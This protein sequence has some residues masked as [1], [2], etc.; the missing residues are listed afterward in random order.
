MA[1]L[2][3]GDLAKGVAP[4]YVNRHEV[5]ATG[6]GMVRQVSASVVGGEASFRTV[7]M[8]REENAEALANLILKTIAQQRKSSAEMLN[9]KSKQGEE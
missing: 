8:M 9:K 2:K 6:D 3:V 1:E 5:T 4:V 7:M